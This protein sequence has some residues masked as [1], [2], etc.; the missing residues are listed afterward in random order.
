MRLFGLIGSPLEHSFSPEYFRKKFAEEKIEAEY[1]LFPLS[2]ISRFPGL[3]RD[4]PYLE[5]LNVTI[6]YKQEVIP[7]ISELEE[8]AQSIGA[9]NTIAIRRKGPKPIGTIGYN[10][11][12]YGFEYSLK[13]LLLPFHSKAL[14]LGTGG[15]AQTVS[16]VLDKLGLD[17]LY[18]SRQEN[19][20]KNVIGYD[21]ITTAH[22]RERNLIINTTPVGMFPDV[23][24]KPPIPYS[25][26]GNQHLL[27]DLVYNPSTTAFLY[28]GLKQGATIKNGYE[29]LQ[30]QAER[31][32]EIWNAST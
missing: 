9:V 18:A 20:A 19:P 22:I 21:A 30:L 1:R 14:I 28:E 15:S 31:S 17:V 5:G 29:M 3:L 16:F 12:A 10:T 32:W 7:F 6:P 11:D 23:S 26:L 24:T 27:F 8:E 13:P 4:H 2:S 25:A